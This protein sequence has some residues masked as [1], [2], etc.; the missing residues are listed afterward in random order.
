M[1]EIPAFKATNGIAAKSKRTILVL[2]EIPLFE[3]I[4]SIRSKELN[5]KGLNSILLLNYNPIKIDHLTH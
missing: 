5:M 2:L 4:N 1:V 3:S